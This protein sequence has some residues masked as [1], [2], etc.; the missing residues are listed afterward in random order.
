MRLS[1]N[2]GRVKGTTGVGYDYDLQVWVK[3]YIVQNCGHTEA[4][5]QSSGSICCNGYKFA[6]QDIRTITR[7]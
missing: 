5:R 4:F 7:G 6:G 1:R 3:G 2:F